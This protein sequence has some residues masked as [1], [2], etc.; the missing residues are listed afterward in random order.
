MARSPAAAP[1]PSG[2]YRASMTPCSW[3]SRTRACSAGSSSSTSLRRAVSN[4][5]EAMNCMSVLQSQSQVTDNAR[6][7]GAGD[8]ALTALGSVVWPSNRADYQHWDKI[9][10][11]AIGT[12]AWA[13]A[14]ITARALGV[15]T[16]VEEVLSSD[17]AGTS[18]V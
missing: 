16:L 12:G 5:M 18:A 3:S 13:D 11:A 14:W 4:E 7:F 6:L 8:A 9:A 15:E 10:R 17:A 1:D 2:T